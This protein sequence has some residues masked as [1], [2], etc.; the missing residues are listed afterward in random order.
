MILHAELATNIFSRAIDVTRIE[1]IELFSKMPLNTPGRGLV[2]FQPIS[3]R[4]KI[5][6]QAFTLAPYA[7]FSAPV[8]SVYGL[9]N[10]PRFIIVVQ[11]SSIFIPAAKHFHPEINAPL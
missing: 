5:G 8:Y 11:N 2:F 7:F 10:P 3:Q 6:L 9:V 1:A 4:V